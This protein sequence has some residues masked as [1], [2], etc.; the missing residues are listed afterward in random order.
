MFIANIVYT[1]VAKPQR[2]FPTA[3]M[4]RYGTGS[5]AYLSGVFNFIIYFAQMKDFRDFLKKLLCRR[6]RATQLAASR[7]M[8]NERLDKKTESSK[9]NCPSNSTAEL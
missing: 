9:K 5:T 4:M 2:D 8:N 7:E 6:S 3:Y 1:Q